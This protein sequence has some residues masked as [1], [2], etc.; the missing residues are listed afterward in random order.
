VTFFLGQDVHM[1][2]FL[3]P[4]ALALLLPF[5]ATAQDTGMEMSDPDRA[6]F[7]AEVRAYLLANPE[8]IFEAIQVFEDRKAAK[9]SQTD[10]DMIAA[11]MDDLHD[12]TRSWEGGNPDGDVTLVE[13][14]DYRCSYCRR[15]HDEVL[16][17]VASDGNIRIITKEF[18]ILG[19]ASLAS[20]RFAV[21]V[22]QLA[23]RD[24]YKL[25]NDA[26]IRLRGEP[27]EATLSQLAIE[28]G[29]NPAE[30]I[31]HAATD[32]VT[33]VIDANRALGQRLDI[34]GTPTFVMNGE[35]MRGYL[36]LDQ[37]RAAVAAVRG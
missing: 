22:L 37:M 21:A 27:N 7:Q 5:T 28:V 13:F 15:A 35:M 34:R 4:L 11:N 3:A 20:S 16:E 25:V 29:L 36:P 6:A 1:R 19:E 23:G 8:V 18:P 14:I 9:Q 26:L 17:L 12:T 31:A 24:T 30:I 2:R 33:D 32:A 10:A